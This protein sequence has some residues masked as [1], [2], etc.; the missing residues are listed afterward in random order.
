MGGGRVLSWGKLHTSVLAGQ[1]GLWYVTQAVL[2]KPDSS[3]KPIVY[4]LSFTHATSADNYLR[5]HNTL[6]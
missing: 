1:K 2:L 3:R 4:I 5:L 6:S